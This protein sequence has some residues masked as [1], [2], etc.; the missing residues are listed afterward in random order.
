MLIILIFFVSKPKLKNSNKYTIITN[1]RWLT[2]QNDGG[3]NT[4][5]YYEID[6]KNKIVNKITENYKANLGKNPKTIISND[7]TKEIDNNT[8]KNL[9]ETIYKLIKNKDI[10]NDNNYDCY[11]IKWDNNKKNICNINN[12]NK[13]EKIL[14]KI[15]KKNLN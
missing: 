12:I 11:E 6:F 9:K 8:S 4:N 3:S 15:D 7:Y 1:S 14:K 2:M 13:L 5:I 10:N